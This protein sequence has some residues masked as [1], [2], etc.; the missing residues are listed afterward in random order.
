MKSKLEVAANLAT[1]IVCVLVAVVVIRDHLM[2]ASAPADPESI[3]PGDRLE[4]LAPIVSEDS[5]QTLILA[6]SPA[7]RFCNESLTFYRSLTDARDERH[8]DVSILAVVNSEMARE[9]QARLLQQAGVEVDRLVTVDFPSLNLLVTPTVLAV[10]QELEVEHVWF[11][12]LS[13][14]DEE[15]VR[16][17]VFRDPASNT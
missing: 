1:L 15:A 8:A 16:N 4:A 9:E 3:Q 13:V 5:D 17:A 2:P 12:K 7:C 10:D 14:D 6:L 11:G